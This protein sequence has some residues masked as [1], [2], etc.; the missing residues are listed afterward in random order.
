MPV[1]PHWRAVNGIISRPS[2]HQCH[3]HT[4]G[5]LSGQQSR[6]PKQDSRKNPFTSYSLVCYFFTC[7]SFVSG[8]TQGVNLSTDNLSTE[9]F[10]SHTVAI[11]VLP[12]EDSHGIW[13]VL[14][15]QILQ[16]FTKCC[17]TCRWLSTQAN[18]TCSSQLLARCHA[19]KPTVYLGN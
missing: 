15:T 16:L 7:R 4:S 18:S 1:G 14:N 17:E 5:I 3:T 10:N 19:Q 13:D 11:T 9:L 2:A 8:A 12:L 6:H